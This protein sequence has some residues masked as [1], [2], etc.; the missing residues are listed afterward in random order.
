V[1][2]PTS[3]SHL[4]ASFIIFRVKIGT[5]SLLLNAVVSDL[6]RSFYTRVKFVIN[7]FYSS[8]NSCVT[9]ERQ[10]TRELS[11]RDAIYRPVKQYCHV[12]E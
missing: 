7:T 4:M 10:Y 3:D 2:T 6:Q 8:G 12:Y 9:V 5:N 11:V 1:R